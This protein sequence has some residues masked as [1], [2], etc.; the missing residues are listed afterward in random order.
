MK[1]VEQSDDRDLQ[2][3]WNLALSKLK[4]DGYG[5]A[6]AVLAATQDRL[7][8]SPA[9]ATLAKSAALRGELAFLANQFS[10]A[11]TL[12]EEA[13]LQIGQLPAKAPQLEVAARLT[14]ADTCL[15]LGRDAVLEDEIAKCA[16]I[17]CTQAHID[18]RAAASIWDLF[19]RR[20][21]QWRRFHQL[22]FYWMQYAEHVA[23][24]QTKWNQAE[25]IDGLVEAQG[26]AGDEDGF[27]RTAARQLELMAE[28]D[29]GKRHQPLLAP[30]VRSCLCFSMI[31][32][33]EWSVAALKKTLDREPMLDN[34]VPLLIRVAQAEIMR[35]HSKP[36]EA[37]RLLSIREIN[38]SSVKPSPALKLSSIVRARCQV[39]LQN[40]LEARA[41][42]LLALE[43]AGTSDLLS[44]R[45]RFEALSGVA[46]ACD[47]TGKYS[48]ARTAYEAAAKLAELVFPKGDIELSVAL[49]DLA[50]IERVTGRPDWHSE[51]A[52]LV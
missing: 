52:P 11:R 51:V 42:W 34:E 7:R 28:A 16:S 13:L 38:H 20:M 48:E 25:A 22:I 33:L 8:H 31:E 27:S 12:L 23:L 4:S 21:T 49:Y 14:L 19:R 24:R 5:S 50:E 17:A 32:P 29:R 43:S 18:A 10:R 3:D 46:K 9:I 30:L 6:D 35:L 45:L 2:A 37:L 47:R 1:S 44:P 36:A 41:A 40:L 26:M 39:D 15:K